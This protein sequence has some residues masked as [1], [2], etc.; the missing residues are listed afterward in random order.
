[1][2]LRDVLTEFDPLMLLECEGLR[3]RKRAGLVASTRNRTSLLEDE[4]DL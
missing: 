2:V 3:M 1:M 4:E